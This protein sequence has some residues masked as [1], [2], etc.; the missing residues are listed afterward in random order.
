MPDPITPHL[1]DLPDGEPDR[2]AT[3]ESLLHAGLE[4]YFRG[5][6]ERAIHAWTRVMFL[7]RAHPRARAYI[8]RARAILAERQRE[9]DELLHQAIAA[10]DAGDTGRAREFLDEAVAKGAHEAQ[11]LALR[12]RLERLE[13][14]GPAAV[15]LEPLPRLRRPSPP[16]AL[17]TPARRPSSRRWLLLCLAAGLLIAFAWPSVVQWA[18]VDVTPVRPAV[19]AA[20]DPPLP[21]PQASDL[22]LARASSL[23]ERGH[24]HE[25]LD[26]LAGVR[27]ADPRR[28]DADTLKADIQR[29]LLDGVVDPTIPQGGRPARPDQAR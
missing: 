24:L 8:D 27:L 23:F 20:P 25:A 14:P 3:I 29:V 7:D 12:D 11:G 19:P 9:S 10:L 16:P 26:V 18:A 22:L 6:Y 15:V 5:E 28:A 1:T 17:P 13:T 2:D 21:V 4:C